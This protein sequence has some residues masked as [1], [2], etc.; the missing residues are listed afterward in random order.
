MHRVNEIEI[1]LSIW[2]SPVIYV[3]DETGY[4]LQEIKP[5]NEEEANDIMNE[6]YTQWKDELNKKEKNGN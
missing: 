4:V 5:R 2:G 6:L 3:Y 1:D